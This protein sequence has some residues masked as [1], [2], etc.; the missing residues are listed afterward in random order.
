MNNS[1]LK[2]C[3]QK[4]RDNEVPLVSIFSWTYNH[5]DYIKSSIDS[6]LDQKT[7]FKIEIII[8]DD[9]S[10]D[11]TTEIIKEYEYKYPKI[12]NNILQKENQWSQGK[13]V[14][15]QLFQKSQGRYIALMHGDDYWIDPLK[16]QRQVDFMESNHEYNLV[17]TNFSILNQ[18]SEKFSIKTHLDRFNSDKTFKCKDITYNNLIPTLTVLLRNNNLSYPKKYET[19]YPGD[20]PLWVYLSLNGK[21][22]Y[23]NFKSSVYRLHDNGVC[24]S[25]RKTENIKRYLYAIKIMSGWVKKNRILKFYFCVSKLKFYMAFL[26]FK[27]KNE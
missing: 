25:S 12:F 20:W 15:N 8:H 11:G 6:I 1:L 24:S 14:M 19:I 10:N 27:L 2:V 22:R 13:S 5:R 4:W 23:L 7:N 21:I 17:F 9:A 16:L 3:D 18:N 26:Y